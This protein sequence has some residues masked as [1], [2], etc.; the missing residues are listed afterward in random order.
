MSNKL[1]YW[2]C[3]TS[4]F[5]SFT[6]VPGCYCIG[7]DPRTNGTVVFELNYK[8]GA[9]GVS[10]DTY[11]QDS[12]GRYLKFSDV[13]FFMSRIAFHNKTG[14]WD[15][16][17]I[18]NL[19]TMDSSYNIM[20]GMY[21]NGNYDSLLFYVGIDSTVNNSQYLGSSYYPFNDTSMWQNVT[22][23]Y[24]FMRVQGKDSVAGGIAKPF[25]YCIATNAN[26]KLVI[27]PKAPT[28][29]NYGPPF[30][31]TTSARIPVMITCDLGKLLSVIGDLQIEDS[32]DSYSIRPNLADTLANQLPNIFQYGD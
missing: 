13:A 21:H 11:I 25:S 15:S 18:T 20:A 26:R 12:L 14:I 1:R 32:T 31:V 2:L 30:I 4:I 17:L 3:M 5:Y 23:S 22:A 28:G 6:F 16:S 9:N 19:L 27:M 7:P 29:W 8:V 24:I 10:K